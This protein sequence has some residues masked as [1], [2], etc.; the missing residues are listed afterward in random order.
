VD[1]LPDVVHLN[2]FNFQLTPSILYEIRAF[3]KK[4]QQALKLIYTAHDY[5]LICPNHKLRHYRAEKNC[6]CCVEGRAINCLR[7]KCIHG[8][9]VKSLLGSFEAVLYRSLKTYR[10][11]DTIICPSRF[12]K[13]KLDSNPLFRKKTIAIHNP[14]DVDAHNF[15]SVGA[16][17]IRPKTYALYFGRYSPEK[18]IPTLLKAA[19]S[20]PDIPFVFA[21]SGLLEAEIEALPNT[22]NKGFLHGNEL[23]NAVKNAEFTI[24][25]SEWYENC[26]FSVMEALALGTPVIAADIGG[27]PELVEAEVNGELFESG[28]ATDLS[29]KI[30]TL[31]NDTEKRKAYK[32]ACQ[33][34]RFLTTNEYC[35]KLLEGIY[36]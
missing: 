25:P 7:F 36:Q 17:I 10:L 27:V 21:G 12:M 23:T 13:E 20:L 32:A 28:N 18:G 3:K 4:R 15:A 22:T 31:W 33:K 9:F 6:L 5:Q 8:S 16:D 35:Q 1:F 2:N 30:R 34:S 14:V 19:Q 11:I 29:E 24:F 26:P